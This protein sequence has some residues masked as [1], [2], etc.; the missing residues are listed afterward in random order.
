[1][2]IIKYSDLATDILKYDDMSDLESVQWIIK[3]VQDQGDKAVREY[4]E[5]FDNIKIENFRIDRE[6]LK[7]SV[8]QVDAPVIEAIRESIT[9][10]E[11]FARIQK[12]GFKSFEQELEPGVFTGQQIV[13]IRRVG[14]YVPGGNFPLISSVLMGV[15]PA[16]VAGVEEI[17]VCSPPTHDGG[18]HPAILAAADIAGATEFYSIGGVQAVAAMAYGTE[19]IP[20][21]DK[22]V[23]PGN[24][25]VTAAKRLVFG[26]VGIDFIAGPSEI[27]IIADEKANPAYVAADLIGQAEHDLQAKA[28]LVTPS[29]K[30]ADD[31]NQELEKQLAELPS[32][33]IARLALDTHGV[34]L[35]VETLE[36]AVEFSNLK[37]PEHLELQ[38][39]DVDKYAPQ[40]KNYGSLFIGEIAA[41]VLGD[42]SAGLNHTLPT[43]GAARY[44]GGL[45]V[46]DFL[47][48]QTSLRVTEKGLQSI[49]PVARTLAEAEGLHGH[50][51]SIKKRLNQQK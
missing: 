28:Y 21:V 5:K 24:K 51:N 46:K 19:S 45:S 48:I 31:V 41:E 3:D 1:M 30:L 34:I 42:Y 33:D 47:K 8:S 6:E 20:A 10:I 35:L 14:V 13:P 32:A 16:R 15:V 50:A 25:Y 49:G 12:E 2:K 39:S 22:I 44:T 40:L 9:N 43:N 26:K 27:L 38:V 29:S 18:V 11:A 4:T 36:E 17:I 37:A 7:A 23:G